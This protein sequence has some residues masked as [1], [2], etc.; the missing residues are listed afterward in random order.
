[1][2]NYKSITDFVET[3]NAGY[4]YLDVALLNAGISN[5]VY[6]IS[7]EG[8]E[9]TLQVNTISTTLLGLLLLP[10]LRVPKRDQGNAHMIIVS[11]GLHAGVTA[12]DIDPRAQN[13]L[14]AC[15]EPA[16]FETAMGGNRQYAVSK[17][18]IM[19][20]VK[21]LAALATSP[22]GE[23]QVLVTSCCPGAAITGRSSRYN[24]FLSGFLS[25]SSVG[26]L[27]RRI[28]MLTPE[29]DNRART[30]VQSLV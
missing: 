22:G 12:N 4:Q 7:P 27:C 23:P 13:V 14:K 19:F 2:N 24:L 16:R 8:W 6:T 25:K 20:A 21:K 1:M 30:S 29:I 15:N 9:E 10:K 18:L 11:S 5:R 26:A 3:I 28:E 17:L